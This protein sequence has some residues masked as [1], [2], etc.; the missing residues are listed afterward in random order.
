VKDYGEISDGLRGRCWKLLYN[1]SLFFPANSGK[2]TL[3]FFLFANE[4]D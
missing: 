4:P 3:A 1:S 2:Q